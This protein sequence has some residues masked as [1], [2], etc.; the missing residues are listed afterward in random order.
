MV[1]PGGDCSSK[2]WHPVIEWY[3]CRSSL[4]ATIYKDLGVAA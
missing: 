2:G 3:I 4:E 1:P